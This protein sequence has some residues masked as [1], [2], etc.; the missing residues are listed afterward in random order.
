MTHTEQRNGNEPHNVHNTLLDQTPDTLTTLC[1]SWNEPG[2]RAKQ[3]LEW[4]YQR[5]VDDYERMTNLSK[6][7]RTRLT[8]ALPILGSR[9]VARQE[10]SDG[11]VK[12]LLEWRDGAT[13]ECV[14]IPD[15]LRQTA[16]ISTQ[17]GCPV[18][19]V[20]CASGLGGLQRQLT[21]GEVVE[22]VIRIR[23]LCGGGHRLSNV[24]FMGLGEPLAN[25]TT[26][27]HAL[28]TINAD[29]GLGIGARKITVSTVGL[30]TQMRRLADEKM[31]VTL[32]LSLHAPTDELRREII[33]WADR[34]SIQELTDACSYY[35]ERTGREI[36]LEYILLG[37]LNDSERQARLLATVARRMR[38][39]INL[40]AYNPVDG[41]PY[42]RPDDS[43]INRFR[44][45][46]QNRGVNTHLR[47][48]RGIDIDA[49]CGQLR[50]NRIVKLG[51]ST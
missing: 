28:R 30:P 49:A 8:D 9:I 41:L 36:T 13:T 12:L 33:P 47:R 46:L 15:G 51:G 19:C 26:T 1:A 17:V 44:D 45:A 7:L 22:Q 29:W 14:L 20:F 4:V 24:V 50:R 42:R 10:S 48:S 18:G 34:V 11:V 43:S 37:G 32:A 40:I 35:F 38:A 5:N 16:C 39:N 31:Q 27:V 21:A 3:L 25:Y 2:F 6:S 23:A